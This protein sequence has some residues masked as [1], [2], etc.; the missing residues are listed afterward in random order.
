MKCLMI[1][2]LFS[3]V[4]PQPLH[5]QNWSVPVYLGIPVYSVRQADAF[6]FAENQASLASLHH[7]MAGIYAERF[8]FLP[9]MDHYRAAVALITS[10]GNFGFNGTWSGNSDFAEASCGIAYARTLG[11]IDVGVQFN[12]YR[13][14]VASYGHA[15]SVNVE[16]GF[17]L[18][19]TPRF[20]GGMHLFNAAGTSLAHEEQL[21]V[22]ASAGFGYDLSPLFYIGT[23]FEKQE[24]L[25]VSVRVGFHYAFHKK[26][27]LRF[28]ISSSGSLFFFGLGYLLGDFRIDATASFHPQLGTTPGLLFI[29]NHPEE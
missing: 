13:V 2:L 4:E 9:E 7:F 1:Y 10:S 5:A 12:Y 14:A 11:K 29:Y 24:G 28:G 25:P 18:H 17:I 20:N 22:I 8:F 15:A 6:S 23:S 27:F 19:F 16:G 21:P 26:V 3:F